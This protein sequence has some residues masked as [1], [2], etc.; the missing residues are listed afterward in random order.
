M[1]AT[2]IGLHNI[3]IDRT[4]VRLGTYIDP[5]KR[6]T[7]LKFLVEEEDRLGAGRDQLEHTARRVREGEARISR[8]LAIIEGLIDYGL[9]NE[10]TFSKA[11]G[12]L[13]TIRESQ[14]LLEQ[15]YQRI[16]SQCSNP[17]V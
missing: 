5:R 10:E 11:L 8:T 3:N 14:V 9:M 6:A 16:L 13:S 2:S 1:D 12:V 15:R 7:L 4:L 17:E